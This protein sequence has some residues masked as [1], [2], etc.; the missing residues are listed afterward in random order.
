[1]FLRAAL[2]GYVVPIGAYVGGRDELTF[3]P[4]L[5]ALIVV[6][7]PLVSTV[8][9]AVAQIVRAFRVRGTS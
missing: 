7:V 9:L 1:M 6:S 3:H 5:I 8:G 2:Y 4:N